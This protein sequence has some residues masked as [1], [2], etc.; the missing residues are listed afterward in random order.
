MWMSNKLVS[1]EKFKREQSVSAEV[2]HVSNSKI[3]VQSSNEY[4]DISVIAPKGIS[5]IPELGDQTLVLA[6]GEKSICPGVIMENKNLQPGEL[7]LYSA[8]GANII[9]KNTGEVVING[10][11]I[12]P[13]E[14]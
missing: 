8:G 12:A 2:S 6:V 3:M 5:Y 9:L 7:M 13:Q 11:T 1:N 10:Q 14:E 4:R